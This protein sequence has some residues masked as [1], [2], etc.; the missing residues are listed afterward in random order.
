[1]QTLLQETSGE[2][3]ANPR[4]AVIAVFAATFSGAVLGIAGSFAIVERWTNSAATK[5]VAPPAKPPAEL[6]PDNRAAREA[7]PGPDATPPPT[8]GAPAAAAPPETPGAS[9]GVSS[10]GPKAAP[11][12]STPPE[13]TVARA[14]TPQPERIGPPGGGPTTKT[15]IATPPVRTGPPARLPAAGA[16][17]K[18]REV[19]AGPVYLQVGAF[20]TEE[21]CLAVANALKEKGFRPRIVADEDYRRLVFGPFATQ[22]EA[23]RLRA[24]LA[25]SG[26]TSIWKRFA[27]VR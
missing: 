19:D 27:E 1:M 4:R 26:Y 23:A 3:P 13:T 2:G 9:A 16:L 24:E 12:P 22:A 11:A 6:P 8:S 7:S 17:L 5:A 10:T 15:G 25:K 14:G 18:V 21:T 20:A